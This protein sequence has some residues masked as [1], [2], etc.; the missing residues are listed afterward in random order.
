MQRQARNLGQHARLTDH[1]VAMDILIKT[2]FFINFYDD[3]LLEQKSPQD[4][5][6]EIDQD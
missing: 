3:Q 6:D 2:L 4:M 5:P 1:S